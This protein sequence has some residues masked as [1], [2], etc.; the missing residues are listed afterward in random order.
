M[1]TQIPPQTFPK[2]FEPLP[3][4]LPNTKC[5]QKKTFTQ[6][7]PRTLK[8]LFDKTRGHQV[9]CEACLY[10]SCG[11]CG[12]RPLFPP[13]HTAYH[14]QTYYCT[15]CLYPACRG[16]A[17]HAERPK[18]RDYNVFRNPDWNCSKCRDKRKVDNEPQDKER[19]KCQGPCQR[20]LP[21]AEFASRPKRRGHYKYCQ[22]CSYP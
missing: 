1:R 18:T 6:Y 10:P 2:L 21:K 4:T 9:K 5:K 12:D 22:Q 13:P 16:E 17:C 11:K 19:M 15:G 20:M 3:Q 7:A 8:I 14:Q